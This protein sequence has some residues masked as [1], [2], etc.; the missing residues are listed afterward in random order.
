MHAVSEAAIHRLGDGDRTALRRAGLA[1]DRAVRAP[2]LS[3]ALP[4]TGFWTVTATPLI[5]PDL[6]DKSLPVLFRSD[7]YALAGRIRRN[8]AE[9]G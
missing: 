6:F 7:V 3:E 4:H 8:L 2:A 9:T 1:I 5:V